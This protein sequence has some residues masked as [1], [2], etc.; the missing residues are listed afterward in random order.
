MLVTGGAGYVGSISVRRLLDAGHEV[1]VLDSL[2]RGHRWAVDDRAELVVGDVGDAEAVRAAVCCVDAVLH[3]A[4]YI[5]VAESVREPERYF[6]NNAERPKTLLH[7]M[8]DARVDALVFSST[9]AVY[10]EPDVV[11]IPEDAPLRPVNPY[12]ESKRLFE[13]SLAEAEDTWGLRSMSL[14]Y[15]NVAGAMP[16]ATLGEAH[17]PETHIVPRIFAAIRDGAGSFTVFGNDYPTPDGTCIRDYIHVCDLADAH[18][19]ALEYLASGGRSAICNLGT[20]RGWSN[21][22]VVRACAEVAGTKIAV[23]F[24]PRRPGDPAVLVAK[25]GRAAELLGWSAHRSDL[26]TIV[27][28]SWRWACRGTGG[29][30]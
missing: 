10:G 4:G 5:D 19:R 17:D 11:P 30:S 3:C 6:E 14:R 29:V 9:A 26:K 2:E 13:R 16:D 23:S 25:P 21:L 22:E 7:A 18:V 12:G 28:D 20:G 1:V 15:F 8:R 27:G 24:G